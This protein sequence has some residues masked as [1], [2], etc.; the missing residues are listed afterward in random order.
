MTGGDERT[1]RQRLVAEIGEG[2]QARIASSVAFAASAIERR[3]LAHAGFREVCERT[4]RPATKLTHVLLERVLSGSDPAVVE[5]AL[6]AA[7][8]LA[9]IKRGAGVE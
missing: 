7:R 1:L 4:A 5:L 3:Y 2:G 8:A 6:G 9:E